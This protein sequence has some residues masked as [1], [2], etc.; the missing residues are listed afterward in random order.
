MYICFISLLV[1]SG[2]EWSL[3]LS[4]VARGT[5]VTLG[6]GDERFCVHNSSEVVVDT[7]FLKAVALCI[8]L[9]D[10]FSGIAVYVFF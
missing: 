10:N 5:K 9:L 1:S 2:L 4:Q 8:T 7:F 3:C 6:Y